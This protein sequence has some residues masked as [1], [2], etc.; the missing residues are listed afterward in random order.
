MDSSALNPTLRDSEATPMVHDPVDR[1]LRDHF[2]PL[3]SDF[4]DDPDMRDIVKFFL[5]EIPARL[6]TMQNLL[7]S[8][9]RIEFWKMVHQLKGAGGGYGFQEIS[10]S[11]AQLERCLNLSGEQWCRDCQTHLETFQGT[12]RRAHAS[13]SELA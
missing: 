3:R 13:L 9:N 8:G 5:E 12:L 1:H 7:E 10:N 11:A 6:E 2:K 4:H